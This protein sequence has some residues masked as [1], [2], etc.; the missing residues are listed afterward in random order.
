M[1]FDLGT[2]SITGIELTDAHGGETL[3]RH[4]VQGNEI[5]VADRAYAH[6]NG[7]G[8]FLTEWAPIVVRAQL[9]QSAY[10]DG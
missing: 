6:R 3:K 7:L 1:R 10:G 5:S 2:F 8:A 9:G 4:P